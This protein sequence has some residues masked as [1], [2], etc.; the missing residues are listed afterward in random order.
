MW[1]LVL[2]T[3]C[4]RL[5]CIVVSLQQTCDFWDMRQDGQHCMLLCIAFTSIL[6]AALPP[7]SACLLVLTPHGVAHLLSRVLGCAPPF[8]PPPAPP[9]SLSALTR[10]SD[11]ILRA[12]PTTSLWICPA[13]HG[14]IWTSLLPHLMQ[15]S[16]LGLISLHFSFS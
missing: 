3:P 13:W 10:F 15:N 7:Y 6:K 9:R 11:H 8:P 16:F 1:F 12:Y 4:D 5:F 2:P 14:C